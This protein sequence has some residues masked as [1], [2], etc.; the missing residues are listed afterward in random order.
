[1]ELISSEVE[2]KTVEEVSKYSQVFWER[3]K[4]LADYERIIASIEKGE[5]RIQRI[6]ETNN[7]ISQKIAQYRVPLQQIKFTY[8]QNKGKS[9]SDEEDRFLV[10]YN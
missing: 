6:I 8:G 7:A 3:I 9:Y 4:E 10:Y 5:S 1:L 2:G